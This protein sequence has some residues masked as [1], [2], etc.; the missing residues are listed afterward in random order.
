M[1][2]SD[3]LKLFNF[4]FENYSDPYLWKR[5]ITKEWSKQKHKFICRSSS[6]VNFFNKLGCKTNT[7]IALWLLR[8]YSWMTS[9]GRRIPCL[10]YL[11]FIYRSSK[12]GPIWRRKIYSQKIIKGVVNTHQKGVH[13]STLF[14]IK[15]FFLR[16]SS[17]AMSI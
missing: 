7:E 15:M 6:N 1:I 8:G 5:K 17:H 14:K 3:R 9:L 2:V 4:I 12:I 16:L 11:S 13:I 10:F